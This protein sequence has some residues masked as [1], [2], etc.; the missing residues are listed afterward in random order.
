[1]P[2]VFPAAQGIDWPPPGDRH[3]IPSRVGELNRCGA[4]DYSVGANNQDLPFAR[5]LNY[6]HHNSIP[7]F[8][9]LSE[10]VWAGPSGPAHTA[11]ARGC[12]PFVTPDGGPAV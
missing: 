4:S 11:I 8:R 3:H 10:R 7:A 2:N 5:T 12:A 9:L 1:M 6:F